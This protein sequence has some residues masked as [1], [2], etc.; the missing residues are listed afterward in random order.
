MLTLDDSSPSATEPALV[1]ASPDGLENLLH[2]K[3]QILRTKLEVFALEILD[4]LGHRE[5]NLRRIADTTGQVDDALRRVGRLATYQLRSAR[6]LEPLYR[7][8]FQLDQE[9]RSQDT[10][11]WRD[12][13]P[14]MRDFLEVW[15]ALEQAKSRAAFLNHAGSGTPEPL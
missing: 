6:E 3:S 8:R 15:E 1:G 9:R 5:R 14:V 12:F 2:N 13:V 10:D 11:A 4:R 7:Q